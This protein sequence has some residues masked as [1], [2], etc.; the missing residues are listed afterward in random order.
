MS[1]WRSTVYQCTWSKYHW[2]L[3]GC[4]IPPTGW[5]L[6]CCVSGTLLLWGQ[7]WSRCWSAHG[8]R[9]PMPSRVGLRQPAHVGNSYEIWGLQSGDCDS[10]KMEGLFGLPGVRPLTPP[11]PGVQRGWG[12]GRGL[13]PTWGHPRRARCLDRGWLSLLNSGDSR[14]AGSFH[15]SGW[16]GRWTANTNST[17]RCMSVCMNESACEEKEAAERMK[18]VVQRAGGGKC[19]RR[20]PEACTGWGSGSV[21]A[22]GQESSNC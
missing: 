3:M 2:S 7:L 20:E 22:W 19:L 15:F 12:C 11:V 16:G 6:I 21:H 13:R 17:H 10:R 18:G 9:H 1:C 14:T 4:S 5:L 8:H